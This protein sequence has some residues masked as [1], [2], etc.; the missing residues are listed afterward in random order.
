[1]KFGVRGCKLAVAVMHGTVGGIIR[2]KEG[3]EEEK[4][5]EM[6][7]PEARR[8]DLGEQ[9]RMEDESCE[10]RAVCESY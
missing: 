8:N 10:E 9:K 4:E 2:K 7:T 3:N 5:K 6:Q 1:M